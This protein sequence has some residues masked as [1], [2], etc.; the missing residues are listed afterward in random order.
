[1]KRLFDMKIMRS[2]ASFD[3][4][5]VA[6]VRSD[7][8]DGLAGLRGLNFCHPG[9]HYSRGFRWTERFLKQFERTV[10]G[11]TCVDGQ[12]PAEIE[13]NALDRF[14]NSSCRPGTWSHNIEEDVSLSKTCFLI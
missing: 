7:H 3:Y 11:T 14:F 1:M 4:A 13:V 10:A 5:S 9:Y 12:S 2:L 8:V 6:I